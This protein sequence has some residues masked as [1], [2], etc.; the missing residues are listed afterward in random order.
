MIV[1]L[2]IS[3]FS[4]GVTRF[5]PTLENFHLA[6]ADGVTLTIVWRTI[7][8]SFFVTLL[9]AVLGFPV[10]LCMRHVGG[11]VRVI[12]LALVVAPLLTSV[13]VRNVAWLLV[14]G[15]SGFINGMLAKLGIASPLPLMY[16]DFGVVVATLHVYLAFA[17][18]PIYSALTG[19]D[20]R[21]EESAAS[22]G[23]SPANV[24]WHVTLPLAMPGLVA[25]CSLVFVLSMGLYLTPV[26]MGGSFVVT[27]S[28]LITDFARNQYNW[29]M[30]S[31]LAIILLAT[32]AGCLLLAW[33]FHGRRR[34]S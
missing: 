34:R 1:I 21:I 22:L 18:L 15:R 11:A 2:S 10:A 20:R 12:I 16:N 17:V 6:L 9:S 31:A 14:L 23:A 13:I 26:I 30:A 28:M 24:F 29:P 33:P 4:G 7:R 25:G 8:L 19:I 32:I 27:V 5:G 3:I